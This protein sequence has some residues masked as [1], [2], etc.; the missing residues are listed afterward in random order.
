MD[1]A[2]LGRWGED[3][4]VE[5]LEDQGWTVVARRWRCA[6]GELDV[7]AVDPDGALVA[8]EVKARRSVRAGSPLEAVDGRRQRRLRGL[9]LAWLAEHRAGQPDAAQ[10]LSPPRLRVDV[11][12]VLVRR[13][14][15]PLLQHVRDA[16]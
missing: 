5:H 8:V 9:L 15:A 13:D 10:R 2:Q 6:R 4:A 7:V 12:G 1:R 16:A 11:V 3:L 14:A